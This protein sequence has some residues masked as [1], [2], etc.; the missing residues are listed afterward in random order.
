MKYTQFII[1]NYK[2]IQ[3]LTVNVGNSIIPLIGINESGKTTILHAILAFDKSKDSLMDGFHVNPKNRYLTR[4]SD[5][6]LTTCIEFEGSEEFEEVGK[7]L[8]LSM[9]DPLYQWLSI[10]STNGLPIH[11]RRDF[12]NGELESKYS[13]VD[14]DDNI[15]AHK[16]ADL[17]AKTLY[18]RLP[19]ILYFD[20][21]SDRV[22]PEVTFPANFATD[23]KLSKGRIREWQEIIQE[24]FARALNEELSLRDFL[25]LKDE[26]DRSN[27]LSDVTQTLNQEII[28]EWQK[29]KKS[30]TELQT[31]ESDSLS[32][33]IDYNLANGAPVFK[34]KVVDSEREQKER[35]FDIQVR[36]KGFQWF[37]NFIIKLRFNP[38]YRKFPENAIF[39]LDEPGSY[40]H[41]SAQTGLLKVL[42]DISKQ[43]TI[44]YC[45]HSQYLLD[46]DIINIGSIK[47]VSKD[48]GNIILEDYGNS[49]ISREMGA[50]SALNHALKLKYG[51]SNDIL[52]RCILTEGIT[53]YYL[54]K[55]LLPFEGIHIIPGSGCGHLKEMISLL[56]AYSDR[57]L[58]ILDND[59]E[60]RRNYNQY[61]SFFNNAFSENAY[62]YSSFGKKDADFVLEDLLSV[63]D[64]KRLM[65]LTNCNDVKKAITL[66]YFSDKKE[67]FIQGIDNTTQSNISILHRHILEH[68]GK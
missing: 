33:K 44:L 68:L 49:K 54:L 23:G 14:E 66:I 62:Q 48:D 63:E 59:G 61:K 9:D 29:L 21:F 24:I 25:N 42:K 32:L 5:C 57:F 12:A 60:G 18:S 67:E 40:L 30:Y 28:T 37:F 45:T 46:P 20:D 1:K 58:V 38:K 34:F 27:Y 13:I 17:L 51:F 4:Q 22:P 39:L 3:E 65:L 50:F 11:L 26:D 10:K 2:A 7:E 16:K 52:K 8:R 43:N 15:V 47:I 31:E 6:E 53:D 64:Q 56:I 19:N 36:S 55:M 35:V 41:S